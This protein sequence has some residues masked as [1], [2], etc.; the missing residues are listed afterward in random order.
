MLR[1]RASEQSDQ[2]PDKATINGP[3]GDYLVNCNNA[4]KP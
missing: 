3:A 1:Q 2:Q 4:F